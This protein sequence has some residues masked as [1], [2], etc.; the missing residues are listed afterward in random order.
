MRKTFALLILCFFSLL[1]LNGKTVSNVY[2]NKKTVVKISE[3]D[4]MFDENNRNWKY[5]GFLI[6]I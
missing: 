6:K 3:E 1:I 5:D 2:L 4:K